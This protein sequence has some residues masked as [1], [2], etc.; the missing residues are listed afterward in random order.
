MLSKKKGYRRKITSVKNYKVA[1]SPTFLSPYHH[2]KTI[3]GPKFPSR[4]RDD[5]ACLLRG[6]GS[7]TIAPFLSIEEK[8][9]ET[10]KYK[11]LLVKRHYLRLL[12]QEAF[13]KHL[14]KWIRELTVFYSLKQIFIRTYIND[15]DL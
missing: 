4:E 9:V 6:K 11:L 13:E 8:N 5:R 7:K 10:R 2:L 3:Q 12:I 14:Q 1:L 15:K